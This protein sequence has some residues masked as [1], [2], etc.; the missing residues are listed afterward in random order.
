MFRNDH[1]ASV[2]PIVLIIHFLQISFFADTPCLEELHYAPFTLQHN[3][4]TMDIIIL[5]VHGLFVH[6][7]KLKWLRWLSYDL[8]CSI[9][10]ALCLRMNMFS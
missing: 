8:I 4:I 3:V 10:G 9:V 5:R 2:K 1:S 6:C 7:K